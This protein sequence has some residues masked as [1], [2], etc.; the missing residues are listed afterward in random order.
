MGCTCSGFVL[1]MLCHHISDKSNDGIASGE[2]RP[3]S[4]INWGGGILLW[5]RER[6]RIKIVG[7]NSQSTIRIFV[8]G[9]FLIVFE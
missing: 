6:V 9:I 2:K 4:L 3:S 7:C 8:T 5:G 1:R